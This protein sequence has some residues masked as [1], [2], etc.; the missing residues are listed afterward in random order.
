MNKVIR[1]TT[2]VA[3][4]YTICCTIFFRVFARQL[5]TFFI[6]D[7]ASVEFGTRFLSVIAFAAPLCALSF[8]ANTIFQAAGKRKASFTLSIMRKG[9]VDIPAMYVF[10]MLLGL[11]GVTLATP[12]AEVTSAITAAI[13]YTRFRRQLSEDR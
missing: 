3:L 1:V 10:K 12:F 6:S 9:V 5:I 8:M 11:N 13:L 7:P 4:S 2:T